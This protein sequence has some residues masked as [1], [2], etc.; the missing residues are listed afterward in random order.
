MADQDYLINQ[1]PAATGVDADDLLALYRG[2]LISGLPTHG[3][4]ID[5]LFNEFVKQ[6]VH[7]GY[8]DSLDANGDPSGFS[9]TLDANKR[10]IAFLVTAAPNAAP[11]SVDF[12][13]K[14]IEVGRGF[15]AHRENFGNPHKL[16]YD[17][18]LDGA[19]VAI[20]VVSQA[21]A[22]AGSNTSPRFWTAQRVKQAIVA[23]AG[24]AGVGGTAFDVR[25]L[26]EVNRIW[27]TPLGDPASRTW[28]NPTL[29]FST[30]NPAVLPPLS[31]EAGMRNN[32]DRYER[33][34]EAPPALLVVAD[35]AAPD[36]VDAAVKARL[37]E[38]GFVVTYHTQTVAPPAD[39]S[40]VLA[41][42]AESTS[43]AGLHTGW[44]TSGIPVL[45]GEALNMD[46]LRMLDADASANASETTAAITIA[47]N[48]HAAVGDL[49]DGSLTIYTA[50]NSFSHV[51]TLGLPAGAVVI[52]E[53]AADSTRATAAVYEIGSTLTTGT[54]PARRAYSG[55]LYR[56]DIWTAD[57]KA[58]FDS[59]V[60]WT[61]GYQW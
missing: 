26:T 21:E 7:V 56:A 49:A 32:L 58:L 23:L 55:H 17:Q 35:A 16:S 48:G 27:G 6:Y 52:A 59:L 11:T 44:D 9:L 4:R 54:A 25:Q 3:L 24:S 31:A 10:Y 14:W 5:Q 19:S 20:G 51:A 15:L 50:T 37:E 18:V 61:A 38:L 47:A 34:N 42:L 60:Y 53:K 28:D 41:V 43:S 36:A 39:G 12:A 40:Y 33:I 57:A 30:S 46:T 22:E 13:G 29:F 45:T 2:V 1:L 8:A